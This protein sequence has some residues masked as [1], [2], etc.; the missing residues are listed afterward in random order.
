[1]YQFHLIRST[2]QVKSGLVWKFYFKLYL[3]KEK[4]GSQLRECPCRWHFP[5][6]VSSVGWWKNAHAPF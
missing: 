3:L 6:A 5:V 4:L 1:M 2:S